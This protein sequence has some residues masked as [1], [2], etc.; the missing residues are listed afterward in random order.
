METIYA[1]ANMISD[2]AVLVIKS[3]FIFLTWILWN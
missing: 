1:I 3:F 2:T